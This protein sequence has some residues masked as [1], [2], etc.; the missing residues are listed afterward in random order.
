MFVAEEKAISAG[1]TVN[2]ADKGL[3]SYRYHKVSREQLYQQS[4][5]IS[6]SPSE[7]LTAM[8]VAVLLSYPYHLCISML[9]V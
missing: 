2:N 6:S 8:I 7:A 3:S 4:F 9:M 1:E 5:T